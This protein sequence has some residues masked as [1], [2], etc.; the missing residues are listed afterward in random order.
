MVQSGMAS[1]VFRESAAISA[2]ASE[3][4]AFLIIIVR[5]KID[6]LIKESP[7]AA[8]TIRTR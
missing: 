3:A 4:M 6:S 7:C 2:L 5:Y 1:R 8:F